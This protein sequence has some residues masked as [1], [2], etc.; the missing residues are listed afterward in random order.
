MVGSL[1]PQ[2]HHRETGMSLFLP[3]EPEQ[4]RESGEIYL[5]IGSGSELDPPDA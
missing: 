3:E 2:S 5:E 4:E 1:M